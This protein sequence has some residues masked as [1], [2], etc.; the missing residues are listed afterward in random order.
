MMHKAFSNFDVF[1]KVFLT[2]KKNNSSPTQEISTTYDMTE[3]MSE[4]R[5]KKDAV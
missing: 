4:Y 3:T 1:K 2:R 5:N